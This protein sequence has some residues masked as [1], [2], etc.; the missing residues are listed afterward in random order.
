MQID[1]KNIF[2]WSAC[3]VVCAATGIGISIAPQNAQAQDGTGAVGQDL[4]DGVCGD[5]DE[6]AGEV[7]RCDSH[8]VCKITRS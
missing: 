6:E 8:G 4:C 3:L 2:G 1:K 5:C 7:C